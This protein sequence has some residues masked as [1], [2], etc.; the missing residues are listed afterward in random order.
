MQWCGS[1]LC[2]VHS[3]VHAVCNSVDSPS[4]ILHRL[5][6]FIF[7]QPSYEGYSLL[8]YY[9]LISNLLRGFRRRLLPINCCR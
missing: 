4:L 2:Q 3:G 6:E 8:S 9:I 5:P 1:I 7:L